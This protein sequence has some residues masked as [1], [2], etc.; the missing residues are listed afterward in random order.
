M[1]EEDC[2]VEL[3]DQVEF[4]EWTRKSKATL[5]LKRESDWPT[6]LKLVR[7]LRSLAEAV[8]AQEEAETTGTYLF[9]KD[10]WGPLSKDGSMKEWGDTAAEHE[11]YR[12]NYHHHVP[13]DNVP[14]V[15]RRR[16]TC[17]F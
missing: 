11:A 13:G 3:R 12:V 1:E 9:L 14:Y 17:F 10:P 5:W 6:H 15:V 7:Q 4:D 2:A 16:V 8:Q